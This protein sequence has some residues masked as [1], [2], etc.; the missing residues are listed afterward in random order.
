MKFYPYKKGR[1]KGFSHVEWGVGGG[2]GTN[3]LGV[4]FMR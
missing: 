1:G 4:V 3:S 2:V